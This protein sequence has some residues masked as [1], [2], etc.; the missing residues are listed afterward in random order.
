VRQTAPIRW[1]GVDPQPSAFIMRT[2]DPKTDATYLAT[3]FAL[4]FYS[5]Q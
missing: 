4:Y 5:I 2:K 1:M 3:H